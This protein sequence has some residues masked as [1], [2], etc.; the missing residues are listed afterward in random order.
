MLYTEVFSTPHLDK[1]KITDGI[2]LRLDS[3]A[4]IAPELHIFCAMKLVL[5]PGAQ[6]M[7]IFC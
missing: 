1:L 3:M 2:R 5:P 4:Q 7:S 6:A